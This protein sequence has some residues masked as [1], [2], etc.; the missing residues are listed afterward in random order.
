MAWEVWE[1][2]EVWECSLNENDNNTYYWDRESRGI[3]EVALLV[4][5][6]FYPFSLMSVD[7][8]KQNRHI[9]IC[10]KIV[11]WTGTF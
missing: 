2:W 6:L 7:G 10:P 5:L 4:W 3:L 1:V 9:Q 8:N 11:N